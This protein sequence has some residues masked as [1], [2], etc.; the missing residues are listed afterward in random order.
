MSEQDLRKEELRQLRLLVALSKLSNK[1]ALR[2]LRT[3][4]EGDSAASKIMELCK[5]EAVYGDIVKA[6]VD[7]KLAA[8]RTAQRKIAELADKG[9]LTQ[10]K[11]GVYVLSGL[12]D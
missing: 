2:D 10:V 9:V 4:I 12:L 3:E 11:R 1:Q 7:S 8:E 5:Q 6:L